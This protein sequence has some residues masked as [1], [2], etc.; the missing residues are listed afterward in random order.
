[1]FDD[2]IRALTE[3]LCSGEDVSHIPIDQL[4]PLDRLDSAI[5]VGCANIATRSGVTYGVVR[6]SVG[7]IIAASDRDSAQVR[8]VAAGAFAD[9]APQF[10]E[11]KKFETTLRALAHVA[12]GDYPDNVPTQALLES[13]YDRGDRW[14]IKCP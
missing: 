4:Y 5:R 6:P 9:L 10:V 12:C 2:A 3:F 13:D 1:M 14:A 11:S 7:H 8:K